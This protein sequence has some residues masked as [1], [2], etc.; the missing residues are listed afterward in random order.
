MSTF[1]KLIPS[2]EEDVPFG[3]ALRV[4]ALASGIELGGLDT[5]GGGVLVILGVIHCKQE[6]VLQTII[7]CAGMDKGVNYESQKKK[8]RSKVH[9][10]IKRAV[11]K[12]I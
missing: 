12:K 9:G 5:A 4:W 2:L 10:S 6:P 7:S 3:D 8:P 11:S 1:A